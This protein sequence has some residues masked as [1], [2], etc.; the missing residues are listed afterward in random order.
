MKKNSILL[1]LI[2]ALALCFV[3]VLGSYWFFY[4]ITGHGKEFSVP[5]FSYMS[6]DDAKKVAKKENLKLVVLDS[7]YI[8]SLP[9]GIVYQQDPSA[10]SKVKKGRT[11]RVVINSLMPKQVEMPDLVGYSLRQAKGVLESKGLLLG[12]L[13]YVEDIATNNVLDQMHSGLPIEAGSYVE[14]QSV[15]D[16]VLGLES[17]EK[18]TYVPALLGL[19]KKSALNELVTNSLNV[20][21][22]IYDKSIRSYADSISA[23][24]WKQ[25]PIPSSMPVEIGSSVNIY[26]TLEADGQL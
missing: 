3:L 20:G 6:V 14:S 21:R 22:V 17:S 4:V 8:H 26:L 7:L 23:K 24:V 10:G 1:H 13:T 9:R 11:I 12:H 15:I 5:D 25:E 18:S 2:L 19:D 16:L